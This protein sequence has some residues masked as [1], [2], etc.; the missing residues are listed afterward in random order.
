M[1]AF[2]LLRPSKKFSQLYAQAWLEGKERALHASEGL[3]AQKAKIEEDNKRLL[4]NAGIVADHEMPFLDLMVKDNPEPRP[5]A[6]Y[7]AGP[8]YIGYMSLVDDNGKDEFRMV[9]PNPSRPDEDKVTDA[10][11]REWANSDPNATPWISAN[12]WI[13]YSC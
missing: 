12:A 6:V 8:K 3:P 2:N 13:P 9:I 4:A 5:L 7:L 1:A 10:E 11:L